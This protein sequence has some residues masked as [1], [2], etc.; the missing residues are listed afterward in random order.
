MVGI[1]VGLPPSIYDDI[2]VASSP[3][4]RDSKSSISY[5]EDYC[6]NEDAFDDY[7]RLVMSAPKWL[8]PLLRQMSRQR[9]PA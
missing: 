3:K 8:T 1:N 5:N 9:G 2:M 6:V 7:L 4:T